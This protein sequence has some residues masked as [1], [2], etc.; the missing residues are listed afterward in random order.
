M[1]NRKIVIIGGSAAGPKA[2]ARARRIDSQAEITILEQ[3]DIVSYAACGI[4]YYLS[5]DVKNIKQLIS[6]GPG[7]IRD[8]AYFRQVKGINL[9]TGIRVTSLDR[10]SKTVKGKRLNS[11]EDVLWPYDCL[12]LCL[13]ATPFIPPVEGVDLSGI[14]TCR[15]LEDAAHIMER[16]GSEHGKVAIV[17]GGLISLELAEAFSKKGLKVSIVELKERLAPAILDSEIS[18]LLETYLRE[19]GIDIYLAEKVQAF[20]G[21]G[22]VEKVITDKRDL[23]VDFVVLALGIRPNIDLA[24]HA[25]IELGPTGAIAVNEYLQ[26]SDPAIYAGGDCIEVLDIIGR[27]KVFWPMGSLANKH[28]RVIGDNLA[29]IET[30]FPGVV[31]TAVVKVFDINVG[32]TGLGEKEASDLGYDVETAMAP[33]HDKPGYYPTAEPFVLKIMVDRKSRRILGIQGAGKGDV[34][35]RIDVAATALTFGATVDSLAHLDLGYSPPYSP[36][37]DLI[38]EAS[39]IVRNKLDGLAVSI[40]SESLRT[41]LSE[42]E[43]FILLDCRTRQEFQKNRIEAPQTLHLPLNEIREKASNLIPGKEIVTVCKIGLRSYQASR[44]LKGLGFNN[45]KFLEGGLDL[46][47]ATQRV[48]NSC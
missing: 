17:G 4:P 48:S 45:V 12:V 23:P 19:K 7:V 3:N 46:W 44:I 16:I 42:G 15:T 29:G 11:G 14:F 2:A 9:E 26:T 37:L 20:Q 47:T 25:G 10:G 22:G 6:A 8:A 31:R 35:K 24:K 41:K 13:G 39:N 5:G 27:R 38:I 33:G 30:K 34:V 18:L 28:G 21:N 32:R 43:D 40:S 36:A 1:N